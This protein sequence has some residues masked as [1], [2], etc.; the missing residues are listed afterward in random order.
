MSLGTA[1]QSFPISLGGRVLADPTEGLFFLAEPRPGGEYV[2]TAIDR[3]AKRVR[4]YCKDFG[5]WRAFDIWYRKARRIEAHEI[6]AII[7]AAK[8]KDAK[9]IRDEVNEL[10][11][12]LMRLESLLVAQDA[13]FHRETIDHTRGQIGRLSGMDRTD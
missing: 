9:E 5:Y 4:T 8:A 2:K 3:A 11:G 10:R 12:R 7:Q 6:I 1:S 13:E